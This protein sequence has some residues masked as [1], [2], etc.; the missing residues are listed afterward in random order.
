MKHT[1]LS[2][3]IQALEDLA[4]RPE[5]DAVARRALFVLTMTPVPTDQE[6]RLGSAIAYALTHAKPAS[7]EARRQ[8]IE[9]VLDAEART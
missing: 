1:P 7:R 8:I 3:A 2:R 6:W 5:H 4:L 9:R